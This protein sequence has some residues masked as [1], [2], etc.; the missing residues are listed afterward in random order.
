MRVFSRYADSLNFCFRAVFSPCA[1]SRCSLSERGRKGNKDIKLNAR[2]YLVNLN[3]AIIIGT[4]HSTRFYH[5]RPIHLFCDLC[6]HKLL[7][8][9]SSSYYLSQSTN[10]KN[11]LCIYSKS[12]PN[13]VKMCSARWM[14]IHYLTWIWSKRTPYF[15]SE[16]EPVFN[17]VT[18]LLRLKRL[19]LFHSSVYNGKNK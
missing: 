8:C 19:Y 1:H 18:I 10:I 11:T 6:A 16:C 2:L 5:G 3:N 7:P 9:P 12:I 13:S 14:G 17:N 15:S 4:I